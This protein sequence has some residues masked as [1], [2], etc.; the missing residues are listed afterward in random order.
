MFLQR[1]SVCHLPGT[2]AY[3]P[4]API[5]DEK[6]I[7]KMGDAVAR[8]QI[9]QGSPNMPGFQ[10]IFQPEDV[11]K[12]IG[13]LKLLAYDPTAKKYVYASARK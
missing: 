3:P 13:Y 1:C 9:L 6:I 2:P 11:D 5:L 10:Y 8:R 12:I 4:I 7:S